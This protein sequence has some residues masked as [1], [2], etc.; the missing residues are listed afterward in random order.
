[1]FLFK[2]FSFWLPVLAVIYYIGELLF[3]PYKDII[4]GLDLLLGK[5][6]STLNDHGFLY[7]N[8]HFKILFPGFLIHFFLWFL[9]GVLI[10]YIV[11]VIFR[12]K[13]RTH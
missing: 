8:E 5:I 1:M 13:R 7:D 9:Y 6:F 11:H 2:R 10:D 3:N 12:E 4:F